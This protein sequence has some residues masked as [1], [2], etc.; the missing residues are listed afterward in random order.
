MSEK[1]SWDSGALGA[2]LKSI[3][4]LRSSAIWANFSR[5]AEFLLVWIRNCSDTDPGLDFEN[6]NLVVPYSSAFAESLP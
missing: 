6:F 4:A 1:N 5:E 3:M 2:A